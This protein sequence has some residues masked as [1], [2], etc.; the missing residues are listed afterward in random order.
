MI[1][2]VVNFM[3]FWINV[4]SDFLGMHLVCAPKPVYQCL[5]PPMYS[6]TSDKIRYLYL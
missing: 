1:V 4:I 5:K 3:F 6:L 2:Q